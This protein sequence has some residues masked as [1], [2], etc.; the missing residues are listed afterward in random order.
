M[1]IS[2]GI[3]DF[4]I[5]GPD[6]DIKLHIGT[7]IPPVRIYCTD[8]CLSEGKL[9]Q[10]PVNDTTWAGME[11]QWNKVFEHVR[12][13][14]EN[15]DKVPWYVED[16]LYWYF[17]V[18]RFEMGIDGPWGGFLRLLSGSDNLKETVNKNI[19]FYNKIMPADFQ[20]DEIE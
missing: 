16:I 14:K 4:A 17:R 18:E 7:C 13:H 6:C 2:L 12:Q 8:C 10:F 20:M 3:A 9:V 5:K 19:Q 1:S 15:G 11:G